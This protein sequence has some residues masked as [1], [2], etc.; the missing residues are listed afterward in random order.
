MT[1]LTDWLGP[2]LLQIILIRSLG[3]LTKIA[4]RYVNNIR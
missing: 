1:I 3:F 4:L 2:Y